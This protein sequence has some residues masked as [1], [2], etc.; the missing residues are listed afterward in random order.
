MD[1]I[2]ESWFS[3]AWW[4]ESGCIAD[5]Q[6]FSHPDE[7]SHFGK[8]EYFNN[9][10]VA[11]RFHPNRLKLFFSLIHYLDIFFLDVSL[12]VYSV[13]NNKQQH[14]KKKLLLKI[15]PFVKQ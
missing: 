4:T 15:N 6:G 9:Q 7:M 8:F 13:K 1:D 5:M 11:G 3:D 2:S 14:A 12:W 10:Y